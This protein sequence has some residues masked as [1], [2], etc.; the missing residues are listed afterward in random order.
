MAPNPNEPPRVGE[1]IRKHVIPAG[2]SVKEAASRLGVGRPALSNLLNSN[3]ALSPDMAARLEKCFG[4]DRQTLLDMQAATHREKQRD[5][6]KSLAVRRYVPNFLSIKARQI[7]AWADHLD[8]RQLL[9]VLLRRLIHSTAHDLR[10]VDFPGFDNAERKGSDGLVEAD[11]ATAW[12]PAGMS[13]WEFGVSGD[14]QAKANK[15][16]AARVRSVPAAQRANATFVFVT[17]RH[18]PGKESW[19]KKKIAQNEWESISVFDANDLEQWLEESIPAQIWLAE[20]L[21]MPTS[22]HKTLDRCWERWASGSEPRMTPEV[23]APSIAAYTKPFTTW[24]GKA[25]D[26]PFVVA[27]DSRDEALAFLACMFE[28]TDAGSNSKHL[29]AVFDSPETLRSLAPSSSPFIPIVTTEEAERELVAIYRNHHSIVVRPRNAADS[30]PDIALDLLHHDAFEKALC[31]MKITGDAADRLARESGMSPTILRRRLSR[32]DAIKSP[33]WAT[34]TG[35]A[36]TLIPLMLIGAWN[37]KAK[38]DTE[39]LSVLA[40]RPYENIEV[41]VAL[42]LRFDDPPVWSGGNYR[43]VASKMDLIFAV[44]KAV[45]ENDLDEFFMLA[46]YVL[47]EEDPALELPEDDRWAAS[48]YGK[49]RDHSPALREGVCES[50]VI[51][52]VHGNNLFKERLGVDVNAYVGALIERLLTPLTLDRLMSNQ[53]DLPR[54]AEAAP[55]AFLGI[56]EADLNTVE[57][58]VLGLLKP[59][60]TGAFGSCPRTGLLWALECLGWKPQNLARVTAV[61]AQLSRTTINDNWMNKP[62]RSLDAIFRSSMPQTAASLEERGK[63]LE[64]LVKRFPDVA[65]QICM[66]QFGPDSRVGD[67]SY[68]PRWRGDASGAGQPVKTQT[69]FYEFTRKS[70]DLALAWSSHDE[71]TLGDLVE[72]AGGLAEEDRTTLWKLIEGWD[73]DTKTTDRAKAALRERVRRFALTRVG[74]RRVQNPT[75]RNRARD[76]YTALEPS[77]P[78]IKHGWLFARQWVEESADELEDEELDFTAREERVHALRLNA[79]A[80]IWSQHGFAGITALLSESQAEPTVGQYAA[81]CVTEPAA[82]IEFVRRCLDVHGDLEPKADACISGFLWTVD[83]EPRRALLR[84]AADTLDAEQRVRLLKS[85]PFERATWLIVDEYGEEFGNRYW[86]A[87]SPQWGRSHSE[88]D[89]NELV[90]RLLNVERPRAAFHAAHMDWARLETSRIKRLLT[91]VSSVSTEPQGAYQLD[92]HNISQALEALDG[93]AGVTV[94]DMA[95]MEFRFASALERSEHGIPNLERQIADSPLLYMQAMALL[96]KRSDDGQDPPEWQIE[97]PEQHRA[98]GSA[99]RGVIDQIKR[100]PGTNP[101]GEIVTGDLADWLELVRDLAT[102]YGRSEITDHC[103]GQL[104]AK[105]PS[106]GSDTWPCAPVCEAMEHIASPEIARGFSIGVRNSRGAH[107][108]GEGGKQ[109]RD[110]AAKYRDWS[111][112]IAFEYPYVARTLEDIAASYDHEAEWQDSEAKVSKRLRH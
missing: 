52:S 1:H 14:A 22:G 85:S 96:W 28:Q 31:A 62:I 76:I 38:A 103:I 80:E 66:E 35:T 48:I 39:V 98:V 10:R 33:A 32:V 26:R 46:E 24:L 86:K 110:L 75:T 106:E 93:R 12:V 16:Y 34:D 88:S 99:M 18:W 73:A 30:E 3:A 51:L 50:L 23:F 89:L 25:S 78:V 15:D 95:Q 37:A 29:A 44:S 21:G 6:E 59:A 70:V 68:R 107:W 65:W 83:A 101:D 64:L 84:T 47:S 105:A 58:V 9:P 79:L 92:A 82:R 43:G 72:R 63:A 94:N 13:F 8:A 60:S 7:E 54:Y 90:D 36:R 27:A 97:D 108:R 67:Y 69:E 109:E 42:L 87:V 53:R 71:N 19:L 102:Q 81:L 20:K 56:I 40:N 111:Q 112:K 2:M 17:P 11:S 41:D 74:R 77:D 55:D 49:V 104:L 57:P 5:T 91:E 100:I 61:L 4:A 45:T